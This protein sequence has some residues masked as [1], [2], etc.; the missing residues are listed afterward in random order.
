MKHSLQSDYD[1]SD[2][3]PIIRLLLMQVTLHDSL[4]DDI[5]SAEILRV[6]YNTAQ[7]FKF[8]IRGKTEAYYRTFV[9]YTEENTL[10]S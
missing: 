4:S 6:D 10:T 2:D 7:F 8:I 5:S 3:S 1:L 9:T